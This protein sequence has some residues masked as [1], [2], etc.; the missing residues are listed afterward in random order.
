MLGLPVNTGGCLFDLDGVLADTA[1]IH[2]ASDLADLLVGHNPG[3]H[4]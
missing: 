1:S 3:E 4:A 2:A